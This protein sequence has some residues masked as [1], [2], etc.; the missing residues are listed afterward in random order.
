MLS[1][2]FVLSVC[3]VLSVLRILAVRLLSAGRVQLLRLLAIEDLRLTVGLGFPPGSGCRAAVP[4]AI[5]C[6]ASC[7]AAS[8]RASSCSCAA[9]SYAASSTVVQ[10]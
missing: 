2:C 5:R 8:C 9:S 7:C 6:A 10:G 4:R 3:C 1:V